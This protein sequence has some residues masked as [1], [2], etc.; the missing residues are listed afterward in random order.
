MSRALHSAA[1]GVEV[2][3]WVVPGGSR[4]E[5]AGMHGDRVKVKTAAPAEGGRATESV[6]RLLEDLF[7]RP[8]RL[9]SGSTSRAKVFL[10]EGIDMDKALRDLGQ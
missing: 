5:I 8:V 10:V 4:N 6:R 1:G 7:G 3:I 9:V 2:R